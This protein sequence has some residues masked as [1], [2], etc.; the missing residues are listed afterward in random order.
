MGS[1]TQSVS[2]IVFGEARSEPKLGPL[3]PSSAVSPLRIEGAVSINF[4]CVSYRTGQFPY[5]LY[6]VAIR[7][8]LSDQFQASKSGFS[9]SFLSYS[10]CLI[11]VAISPAPF[12]LRLDQF[13]HIQAFS[14]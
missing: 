7:G 8:V 9:R 6:R 4:R 12:S 11:R 14:T 1:S 10:S 5:W 13:G 3:G 2:R